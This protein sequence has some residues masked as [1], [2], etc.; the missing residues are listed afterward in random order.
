MVI[1]NWWLSL[2]FLDE[3]CIPSGGVNEGSLDDIAVISYN[4]IVNF[5]LQALN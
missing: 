4:L 5:V 2:L 1:N 3:I